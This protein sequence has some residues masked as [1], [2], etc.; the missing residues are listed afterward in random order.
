MDAASTPAAEAVPGRRHFRAIAFIENFSLK[1]L[2]GVCP[3]ARLS[4]HEL[5][6]PLASG[7][8]VFVYPF[9]A[10]V[11]RDAS[12]AKREEELARLEAVLPN[13]TAET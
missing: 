11:F 12:P 10:I 3:D 7:G 5:C 2:A 8:D 9:G 4:A 6:R 13:L 1:N